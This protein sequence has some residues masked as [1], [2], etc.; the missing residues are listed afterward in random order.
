MIKCIIIVFGGKYIMT[1]KPLKHYDTPVTPLKMYDGFCIMTHQSPNWRCVMDSASWHT[2]HPLKVYDGFF[3]MTNGP[4]TENVWKYVFSKKC[5]TI[6]K[7]YYGWRDTITVWYFQH[8]GSISKKRN[9]GW[10]SG[11]SG[12]SVT[13]W[14]AGASKCKWSIPVYYKRWQILPWFWGMGVKP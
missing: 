10:R 14:G 12:A 3:I 13:F 5:A 4:P 8:S 11:A 7:L 9:V 6:L 1:V 2:G